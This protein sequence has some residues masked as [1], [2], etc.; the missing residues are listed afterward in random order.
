[1]AIKNLEAFTTVLA[2]KLVGISEVEAIGILRTLGVMWRYS[3]IDDEMMMVTDDY[4]LNRISI[5]V[6]SGMIVEA[7]AG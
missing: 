4:R 7:E 3:S 5:A 1:M 2:S 6:H